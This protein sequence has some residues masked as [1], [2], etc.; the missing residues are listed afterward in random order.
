MDI[1]LH[2]IH[3]KDCSNAIQGT[4]EYS[5]S[6]RCRFDFCGPCNEAGIAVLSYVSAGFAV[7]AAAIVAVYIRK[8]DDKEFGNGRRI[9]TSALTGL[10]LVLSVLTFVHWMSDCYS[11]L[12]GGIRGAVGTR[13]VIGPW[14]ILTI[15]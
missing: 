9:A 14:I 8:I 13:E 5:N 4:F 7:T 11:R 1:G 2:K 10:A 3:V 6:D 12:A 15:Y